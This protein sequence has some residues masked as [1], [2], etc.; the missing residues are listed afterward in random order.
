MWV[1]R[2]YSLKIE[3]E[4]VCSSKLACCKILAGTSHEYKDN[5]KCQVFL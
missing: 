5:F 3:L 2:V 1:I 4:D